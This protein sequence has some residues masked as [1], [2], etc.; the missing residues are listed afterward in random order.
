MTSILHLTK[1]PTVRK[2][3]VIFLLAWMPM[4][5]TWAAVSVYCKHERAQSS[6]SAHPGH[7]EHEHVT[8]ADSGM[9][10]DAATA[11]P[12]CSVCH[13]T[14]TLP[15]MGAL[16]DLAAA[17]QSL[18]RFVASAFPVP[19]PGAPDRPNWRPA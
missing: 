13:T 6:Q 5:L 10:A 2:F 18:L 3:L 11:H 14:T 16:M 19:P 1:I 17:T 8:P 7:H 9:P 15:A 12:D 4:Q